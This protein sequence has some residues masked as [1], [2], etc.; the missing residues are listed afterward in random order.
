MQNRFCSGS[1]SVF[2]TSFEIVNYNESIESC[3]LVQNLV[4]NQTDTYYNLA[5]AH[6]KISDSRMA[7]I[8]Y[9]R[10]QDMLSLRKA[11][12][13]IEDVRKGQEREAS[14]SDSNSKSEL[15]LD[16]AF[17]FRSVPGT[18]RNGTEQPTPDNNYTKIKALGVVNNL[19]EQQLKN[20]N[21]IINDFQYTKSSYGYGYGYGYGLCA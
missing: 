4:P 17:P 7:D 21:I 6:Y 9:N 15:I 11:Q 2:L 8:Y 20:I 18:E 3:K 13:R 5:L 14:I 1:F 16:V 10:Y 12:E 19:F